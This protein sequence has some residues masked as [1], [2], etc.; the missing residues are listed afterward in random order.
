MLEAHENVILMCK[1]FGC[2]AHLRTLQGPLNSDTWFSARCSRIHTLLRVVTQPLEAMRQTLHLSKIQL[3]RSRSGTNSFFIH[4][5]T[6]S[7]MYF[8][9]VSGL[10]ANRDRLMD[11]SVLEECKQKKNALQSMS[12]RW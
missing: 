11:C 5:Y 4:F 3:I 9:S 1:L 7:E 10:S 2:T 6:H 8:G 12:R